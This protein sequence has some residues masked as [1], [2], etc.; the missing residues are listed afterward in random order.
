MT[1]FFINTYFNN[2]FTAKL[3]I[4]GK[5]ETNYNSSNDHVMS[6]PAVLRVKSWLGLGWCAKQTTRSWK[7]SHRVTDFSVSRLMFIA[8]TEI[9]IVRRFDP[10]PEIHQINP[11][12]AHEADKNELIR[13][14]RCRRG[15]WLDLYITMDSRVELRKC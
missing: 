6:C 1:C 3:N 7:S 12:L 11:P 9:L 13:Q 15:F 8:H 2:F 10:C 14:A 4:M 5:R